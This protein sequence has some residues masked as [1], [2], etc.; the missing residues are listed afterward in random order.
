[1]NLRRR[2]KRKTEQALDAAASVSKLWT[3]VQLGKRAAKGVAKAKELRPPSKL[4]RVLSLKWVK[5]GGAVAVVGGAAA[6]V[7]RKLKGGDL[8]DYSGPP[9]SAAVDAAA[10][11]PE[12]PPPLSVAPD[13]ATQERD[14][15]PASGPSALRDNRDDAAADMS[16]EKP[17]TDLL[18]LADD[19]SAE[20]PDAAAEPPDADAEPPDATDEVGA[21]A[22]PPDATAEPP[23]ASAEPPD[24]TDEVGAAAEPPDATAEPPDAD[25]EPPDATDEVGAA[26]EPPDVAAEPPDAADDEREAPSYLTVDLKSVKRGD[27]EE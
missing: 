27:D 8:A 2:Q 13:P 11:S 9:P 1:M 24:A 10:P 4:K 12:T 18:E 21:A 23:D 19:A 7:S 25:A 26:A 14:T 3:E 20:P 6:A 22:E 5:I 17:S 15:E 16:P